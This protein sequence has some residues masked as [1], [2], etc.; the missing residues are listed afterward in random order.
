MKLLI[1]KRKRGG[2]LKMK[3]GRSN[4]DLGIRIRIKGLTGEDAELNGKQGTLT[5]PFGCFPI[6]DV[7]VYLDDTSEMHMGICNLLIG[8]FEPVKKA[9]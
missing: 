7:G 6:G 4:Y 5:H 9:G 1:L 8:E 2:E 3:A